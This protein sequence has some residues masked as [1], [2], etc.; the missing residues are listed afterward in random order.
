MVLPP[1]SRSAF[2]LILPACREI[3]LDISHNDVLYYN[4]TIHMGAGMDVGSL[5]AVA[6]RDEARAGLALPV[7]LTSEDRTCRVVRL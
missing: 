1:Y 2:H 3:E 4:N 6:G 7:R 5:M